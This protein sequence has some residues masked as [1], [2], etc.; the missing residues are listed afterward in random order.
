MKLILAVLA[1]LIFIVFVFIYAR[2]FYLKYMKRFD[3]TARHYGYRNFKHLEHEGKKEEKRL[4]R[5]IER[6]NKLKREEWL[7]R[8]GR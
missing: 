7:R 6:K 4:L 3:N 8:H 2:G 5:E 1:G